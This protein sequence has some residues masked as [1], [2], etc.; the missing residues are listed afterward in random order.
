V[1]LN[2]NRELCDLNS[3]VSELNDLAGQRPEIVSRLDSVAGKV[4]ADI[5]R[6]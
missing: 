3:D 2:V 1:P 5:S 4:R 6:R